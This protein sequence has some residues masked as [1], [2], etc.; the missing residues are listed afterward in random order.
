VTGLALKVARVR[1]RF[2]GTVALEDV[3]FSVEQGAFHAL[4]GGNGSGK[5]TLIKIIGGVLTGDSGHLTAGT[6]STAATRSTPGWA[7]A[8]GIR[9]VHQDLGL[10]EPLSVAENIAL[11]AGY[12]TAGR[13]VRWLEVHR[14][15]AELLDVVGLDIAP[16]TPV[17]ALGPVQRTLVAVARALDRSEGRIQLLVLDEPTA[18]LPA[19]EVHHLLQ[20]LRRLRDNGTTILY[21]THRLGEVL[22]A[23]DAVTVLRDGHHVVTRSAAGLS[24][25]DLVELIVGRPV[26]ALYPAAADVVPA[27][28]TSEPPVLTVESLAGG[29]VRGVD[30]TVFGG[31]VLGIGGTVGAGRTSLLR[32]LFGDARPDQGTMLFGGQPFNP[33]S[34]AEAMAAGVAYV[35]ENRGR[36]SAFLPLG[37][38]ENLSA[39]TVQRYSRL[40]ALRRSRERFDARR[41]IAALDI[42]AASVAAPLRSLSG[43]NQQ[44]VIL[45]RWLRRDTRL[46]LLDEP[47]QGVDVGTR[48]QVYDLI[49]DAA[50]GGIAVIVASSDFEELAGL[51]DRVMVMAAGRIVAEAPREHLSADWIA[52]HTHSSTVRRAA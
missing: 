43:G 26:D 41:D 13:C 37:V 35:P 23:A 3:S 46:L 11:A 22:Q 2:P 42:R 48:A 27:S 38:T 19:G 32:L 51:C 8:A 17:A 39:A 52:H 20:M 18:R 31:E 10:F 16:G 49:R 50:I 45:A 29:A 14:R 44:K 28:A 21:V 6:Q 30:V 40:G 33:H 24:E 7:R 15:A 47:T 36:D 34:P 12:A 1:K 9:I 4:L 5:S 25:Q